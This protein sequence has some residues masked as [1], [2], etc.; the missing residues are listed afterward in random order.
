VK[1]CVSAA[2]TEALPKVVKFSHEQIV[3]QV[4]SIAVGFWLMHAGA[5][6]IY[7]SFNRFSLDPNL[8][9]LV[10]ILLFQVLRFLGSEYCKSA[11][12]SLDPLLDFHREVLEESLRFD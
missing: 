4:S 2:T 8:F 5:D 11:C 9:L 6:E 3:A 1:I 12:L 7:M 10:L